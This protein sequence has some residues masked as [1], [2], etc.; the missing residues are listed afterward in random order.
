MQPPLDFPCM[1]V[2][3]AKEAIEALQTEPVRWASLDHD[4]SF[5]HY[6]E[7]VDMDLSDPVLRAAASAG[8]PTRGEPTGY[9]VVKWMAEHNVWPRDGIIVHSW[10]PAGAENMVAT[11]DRY[12]PY[13][14]I[15]RP[16]QHFPGLAEAMSDGAH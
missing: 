7:S 11:I 9:E 2:K 16:A 4:L 3:T 15:R 5:E 13:R 8:V 10:N 14:A 6:A 1:W 12:A